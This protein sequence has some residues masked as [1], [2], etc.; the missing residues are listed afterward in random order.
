MPGNAKASVLVAYLR[1]SKQP[2]MPLN[3]ETAPEAQI[4]L[5]ETWIDQGAKID[6]IKPGWPYTP[7]VR[8]MLCRRLRIL[9]VGTYADR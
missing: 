8:H 1:G 7:P 9:R 3:G 2:R 5:I 6:T 4:K